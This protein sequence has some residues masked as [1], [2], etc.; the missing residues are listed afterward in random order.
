M[1]QYPQE[2]PKAAIAVV[3]EAVSHPQLSDKAKVVHACYDVLGFALGKSFGE[4]TY[5]LVGDSAIP[6]DAHQQLMTF[7]VEGLGD[8]IPKWLIAMVLDLLKK[9][10]AE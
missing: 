8:H 2:F 7:G 6:T 5:Q 10:L 4:G 1:S 9:Y 3:W